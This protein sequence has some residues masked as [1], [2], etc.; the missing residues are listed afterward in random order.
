MNKMLAELISLSDV[1]KEID[2]YDPMIEE[3]RKDLEAQLSTQ[4]QIQNTISL[5]EE[6]I[7]DCDLK[8]RKN[9]IHLQELGDKLA[10]LSTKGKEVKNEREVKALQLEEEIAKEQI[11]FANE[12]IER[13]DKV[14]AYKTTE[15]EEQNANVAVIAADIEEKAKVAEVAVAEIA[16]QRETSYKSKEELVSSMNPK[17]LGFYEKIRKWA[18]NTALVP[19]KKQACYG[20]FMTINDQTYTDIIRGEEIV[21]CP[22]CGRILYIEPQENTEEA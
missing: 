6:E 7:T 15:I 18:K 16:I 17:I 3:V 14:K 8:K 10:E 9:E 21:T 11:D 12:E 5:L 20:C 19:V 1:N 22:H 13:F 2:S 4:A